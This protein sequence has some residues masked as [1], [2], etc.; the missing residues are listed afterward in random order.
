MERLRSFICVDKWG[1]LVEK[2]KI[3]ILHFI[4]TFCV[5]FLLVHV[6]C[7]FNSSLIKPFIFAERHIWYS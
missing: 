6:L 3:A 4:D 5:E 7:L 2:Y 1:E